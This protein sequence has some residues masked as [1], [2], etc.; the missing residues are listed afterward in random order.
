MIGEDYK[1]LYSNYEGLKWTIL[2][3]YNY[4]ELKLY[5][6]GPTSGNIQAP[7][8]LTKGSKDIKIS[9]KYLYQNIVF[10]KTISYKETI[11]YNIDK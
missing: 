1:W 5:H 8:T 11:K 2:F 10:N 9:S 7:R 4:K 6:S 3:G